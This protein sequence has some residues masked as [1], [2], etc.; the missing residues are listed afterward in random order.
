MTQSSSTAAVP[1]VMGEIRD[2]VAEVRFI[3]GDRGHGIFATRPLAAGTLLFKERP[4]VAMQEAKNRW[5]GCVVCERC[6]AFLGPLEDQVRSLLHGAKKSAAALPDVLPAIPG[7]PTLPL[8]VVCPGGCGLRFCSSACA[9]AEYEQGHRLLCSGS[10]TDTTGST[11]KRKL[12]DVPE[13]ETMLET[14]NFQR[15]AAG[16]Q[17]MIPASR[18]PSGSGAAAGPSSEAA[19][20]PADEEERGGSG[21]AERAMA[22]ARTAFDRFAAHARATNQ[23]FLLA[24]KAC[25]VVLCRMEAGCSFEA[26]MDSFPGP[27]WWEAVHCPEPAA[28]KASFN[29][30]LLKI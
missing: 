8:P 3:D 2:G 7:W 14:L 23:I 20:S 22:G 21:D 12:R 16:A 17:P 13:V 26:A 19:S 28:A 24:A 1:E 5:A 11:S 6:F 4:L 18:D 9:R 27:I 29:S 25:A 15:A 10:Q 30:L